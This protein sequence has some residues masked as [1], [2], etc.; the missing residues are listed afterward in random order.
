MARSAARL[1]IVESLIALEILTN[2]FALSCIASL[3]WL[4]YVLK[5]DL[6]RANEHLLVTTL[7]NLNERRKG[8]LAIIVTAATLELQHASFQLIVTQ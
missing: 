8:T 6:Y 5:S 7:G 3:K 1:Q 2:L 4:R